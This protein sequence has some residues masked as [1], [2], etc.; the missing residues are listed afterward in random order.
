MYMMFYKKNG[1]IYMDYNSEGR[2]YDVLEL[3]QRYES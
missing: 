2:N 3:V 1:R